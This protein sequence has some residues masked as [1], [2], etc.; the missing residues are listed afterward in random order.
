MKKKARRCPLTGGA[1]GDARPAGRGGVRMF[2]V[3]VLAFI[4]A[5]CCG[6]FQRSRLEKTVIAESGVPLSL[7]FKNECTV[8]LELYLT[9][10]E[11]QGEVKLLRVQNGQS[12]MLFSGDSAALGFAE[13]YI[14]TLTVEESMTFTV[15]CGEGGNAKLHIHGEKQET[16]RGMDC[17]CIAPLWLGR[18]RCRRLGA[19]HTPHS[20]PQERAIIKTLQESSVQRF[21]MQIEF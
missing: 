17:P 16:R 1:Y 11:S 6:V 5:F 19:A 12:V 14:G 20:K 4:T 9:A 10:E 13:I 8:P 2:S 18:A 15:Q 3:R 7:V 21:F